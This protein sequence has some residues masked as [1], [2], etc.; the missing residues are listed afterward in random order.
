MCGMLSS[1]SYSSIK[2]VGDAGVI[3]ESFGFE[4]TGQME[5]KENRGSNWGA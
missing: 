4:D 3:N 5:A 1:F 2:I